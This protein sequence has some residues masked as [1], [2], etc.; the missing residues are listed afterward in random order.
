MVACL[1]SV[2]FM[3]AD[4]SRSL[5]VELRRLHNT[6]TRCDNK[7]FVVTTRLPAFGPMAGTMIRKS[8]G[9]YAEAV[10]HWDVTV[11]RYEDMGLIRDDLRIIGFREEG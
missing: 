6:R 5:F 3:P 8:F 11:H 9:T 4:R 10:R 1:R 7:E 2:R